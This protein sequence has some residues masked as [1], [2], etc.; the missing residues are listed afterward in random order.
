MCDISDVGGPEAHPGP[1]D[2][3]ITFYRK[4]VLLGR[5]PTAEPPACLT[6][7]GL[8]TA[9]L[10]DPSVLVPVPPEV[11][12]TA[13]LHP[14]EQQILEQQQQVAAIRTA[15]SQVESVYRTLR[16]EGRDNVQRLS[17]AA[18][19]AA[20]V[21]E[22]T[23]ATERELLTAHPGGSRPTDV[24]ARSL[25]LAL[26]AQKRGVRQRTLYQ[27][28][29]RAHYPTLDYIKAVTEAGIEV[30]TVDEVFDRLIICDRSV[31]F[32]P[33]KELEHHNHALKVTDPGVV[34]FLASVFEHAWERAAPVVYES[35]QQRPPLLTDE[36]RLRVLQLMVD[37]YTDAAI[38]SRLGISSRT[39]ASHLK[40]VS[41]ILGSNSRAQ[42]AYL[43][44]QSGIL[45]GSPPPARQPRGPHEQPT[46]PAGPTA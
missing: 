9:A 3:G 15:M 45:D 31:A 11:A 30:R 21:A 38:A 6:E 24:L 25:V 8:L 36:T 29:V 33:D 37:G 39:V 46:G 17:G 4:A 19:I 34:H 7:L 27:H 10:G 23:Q 2:E 41:E 35:D 12:T 32:I 13:L 22:T 14:M 42:L 5:A 40:R 28:S 44:A 20:A 18:V 16:R 43:T 26:D 1:C